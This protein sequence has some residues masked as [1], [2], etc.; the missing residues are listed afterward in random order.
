[1]PDPGPTNGASIPAIEY[2]GLTFAYAPGER[3]AIQDVTLR[4]QPG[5]RVG[6]LGPN[7]GGKTTLLR[8]TLGLLRP[9]RGTVRVLG[10]APAAAR[11]RGL[12]GYV[13][14][15]CEA[16][17]AFPISARQVVALAAERGEPA[18]RPAGAGARRRTDEA[19][20]LV[21]AS[22]YA[23]SPVGTLSGG[24]LQRV[25]VARALAIQPR[26]LLLDEPTVGVDIPG[27]ER[28][29]ELLT[30][31]RRD[32][33]LT[34]V[35]VSHDLRTIAGACDRV[36][37]LN[38]TLHSHVS[39]GGLTPEIL[40]EVFEHDVSAALGAAVH[41]HAHPAEECPDESHGRAG[42]RHAPDH[43]AARADG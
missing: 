30:R 14:Q 16:E 21:G 32:L 25:L 26:I 43:G 12:I 41:V 40:A 17:L 39:P 27:Q 34:I 15:R 42:R 10:L 6:V 18:W 24:Q 37:C 5:E 38:R 3:P 20:D 13:Q 8:L 23:G 36:A 33:D 31:L 9:T 35:I 4:I 1:M 7:G 11:R 29:L 28:F 22:A 2:D 19:L